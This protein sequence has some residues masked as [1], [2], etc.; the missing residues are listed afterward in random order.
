MAVRSAAASVRR[1]PASGVP[2]GVRTVSDQVMTG[3]AVEDLEHG[4]AGP[5]ET[6]IDAEHQVL[7]TSVRSV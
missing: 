6:G 3:L 1:R 7:R 4:E 5:R 2:A